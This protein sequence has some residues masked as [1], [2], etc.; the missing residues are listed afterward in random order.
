MNGALTALPYT[1]PGGEVELSVSASGSNIEID[2]TFNVRIV[3]SHAY[4]GIEVSEVYLQQLCGLCG[5]Y[6]NDPADDFKDPSSTLLTDKNDFGNSW[7]V[8]NPTYP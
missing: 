2:T 5:F 4:V 8:F 1:S 6:D 7:K 3:C